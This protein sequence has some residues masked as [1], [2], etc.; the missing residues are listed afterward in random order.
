MSKKSVCPHCLEEIEVKN[1]ENVVEKKS[2]MIRIRVRPRT[3]TAWKNYAKAYSTG[4]DALLS[5]LANMLDVR[6]T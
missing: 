3:Q 1:E 5:L 4:E 2:E 6:I